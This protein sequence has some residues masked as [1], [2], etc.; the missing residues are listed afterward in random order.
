MPYVRYRRRRNAKKPVRKVRKG[1]RRVRRSTRGAFSRKVKKVISRMA[2]VKSVNTDPTTYAFNANNSTCSPAVDLTTPL[3]QIATGNTNGSR[4]GNRVQLK[5]YDIRM[6]FYMNPTYVSGAT[7]RPGFVH[8]WF[9]TLKNDKFAQPNATDLTRLYDDGSGSAGPDQT[10]LSTLRDINKDY[11]NIHAYRKFKLGGA[12]SP[13]PNNDFPIQ[14]TIIVK[15]L[16]K[17]QVVWNDGLLAVNK[18]MYLWAHFT[19]VDS[20]NI[21]IVPPILCDYYLSVKYTD[22]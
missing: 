10:V 11:F 6:N 17:G 12:G 8:V 1:V 16:L 22:L 15:N 5:R 21:T 14:K 19:T 9:G 13:Y 7:F 2:E 4:I 3:E 18:S 20:V